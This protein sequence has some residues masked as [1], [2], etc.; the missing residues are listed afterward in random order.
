[1]ITSTTISNI[2]NT[3]DQNANPVPITIPSG[4]GVVQGK[5][6]LKLFMFK[7]STKNLKIHMFTIGAKIKGIK[8]TGLSTSGAPK[9]MGSLTPKNVG[10]TDAL[11]IALFLFDFVNHININGT[12][13]VAPVPPIVAT[14]ICVPG[15]IT[16]SACSPACIKCKFVSRFA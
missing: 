5:K 8:N 15:V 9:S 11:P 1:M 6:I 2:A 12:T 16:L 14:N 13:N 3:N 7:T 4:P 10:T